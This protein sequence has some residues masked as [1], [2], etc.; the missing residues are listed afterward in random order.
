MKIV[1]PWISRKK[2]WAKVWE[3]NGLEQSAMQAELSFA[4]LQ[5]AMQT[6]LFRMEIGILR[7]HLGKLKREN[8][9]LKWRLMERDPE[10]VRDLDMDQGDRVAVYRS[11]PIRDHHHGIADASV[12]NVEVGRA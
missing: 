9:L 2:A 7:S 11:E 1:W 5:H 10:F 4:S 12:Q 6:M 3:M 8:D